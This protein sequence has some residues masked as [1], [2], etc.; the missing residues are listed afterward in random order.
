MSIL[1]KV[2]GFIGKIGALPADALHVLEAA[3]KGIE[4]VWSFLTHISG[5]LDDAWTWMVNGVEWFTGQIGDWAGEVFHTI[6]QVLAETIPKA[7]EWVFD[8]AVK[9]AAGAIGAA[10][11]Q[12]HKLIEDVK[13]FVLDVIDA[14]GKGLKARLHDLEKLVWAPVHWVLKEGAWL[15]N[16]ISHPENIAKW[17]AGAIVVPVAE[18]LLHAGATVIVWVL[19]K[20]VNESTEISHLLEDAF[21]KVL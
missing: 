3:W 12:L 21:D 10:K 13:K 4:S 9:W 16:L 20:L 14:V 5:I 11:G 18:W 2:E 15:W 8:Q 6:W 19:R 7:I 1:S 17:V